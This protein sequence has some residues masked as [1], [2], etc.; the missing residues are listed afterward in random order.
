MFTAN[1]LPQKASCRV[2]GWTLATSCS[3]HYQQQQQQQDADPWMLNLRQY[4]YVYMKDG[5]DFG[6]GRHLAR[7]Q[8]CD[9]AAAATYEP[10]F[11]DCSY[12]FT[13]HHHHQQRGLQASQDNSL[14]NGSTTDFQKDMAWTATDQ[15]QLNHG[16]QYRLILFLHM[17][18]CPIKS[19]YF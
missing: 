7:F 13:S 19:G 15:Y 8:R 5:G 6:G 10:P 4:P 18:S 17:T 1:E 2:T 14:Q 12:L 11:V 9:V 16:R 3:S